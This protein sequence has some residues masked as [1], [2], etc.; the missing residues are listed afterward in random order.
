MS[1][2]EWLRIHHEQFRPVVDAYAESCERL[3]PIVHAYA[4]SCERFRPIVERRS[5]GDLV[6]RQLRRRMEARPD[7][8]LWHRQ[9]VAPPPPAGPWP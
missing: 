9:L 5:A 1:V 8:Y 4:E 6:W 3:R 2:R 7:R